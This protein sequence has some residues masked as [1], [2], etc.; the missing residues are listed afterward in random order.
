MNFQEFLAISKKNLIQF[1]SLLW[2][3]KIRNFHRAADFSRKA[4]NYSH[5]SDLFPF[6]ISEIFWVFSLFCNKD[7]VSAKYF[8]ATLSMTIPYIFSAVPSGNRKKKNRASH[9]CYLEKSW[10]FKSSVVIPK[11][12]KNSIIIRKIQFAVFYLAVS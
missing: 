12:G 1:V 2:N 8:I 5:Y 3:S 4:G 7:C 9:A 6:C 10:L 11:A